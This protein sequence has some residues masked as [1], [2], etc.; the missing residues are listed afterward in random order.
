MTSGHYISIQSFPNVFTV[1]QTTLVKLIV[2]ANCK[3]FSFSFGLRLLRQ[4]ALPRLRIF[5]IARTIFNC[6]LCDANSIMFTCDIRENERNISIFA[7]Y[8]TKFFGLSE[9]P[10]YNASFLFI[11]LFICVAVNLAK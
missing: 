7:N 5:S 4:P 11:H 10:S 3:V 2:T 8:I 6:W 1:S 9:Q